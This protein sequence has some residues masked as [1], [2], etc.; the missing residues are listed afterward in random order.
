M[1]IR[2]AKV[3]DAE[4]IGQLWLELV[5][6]HRQLDDNMPLPARDGHLRYASRIRHA[7][8]DSYQRILVAEDD[9][10]VIGY[11]YGMVIDLVPE[12]FL[13]ERAGMVGDIYVEQEHRGTGIGKALMHTMQD[14]FRLR[15]VRYYELSV[16]SA[17]QPG[18]RFW[19][20][21]MHGQS[22]MIRM[23]VSVQDD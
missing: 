8:N 12:M 18:I 7:L 4:R 9:G 20:H 13:T 19:Q 6:Y 10:E 5:A 17:N 11:V 15:G 16:A 22:I 21:T 1:I 2:P 23:R 3:E 14:W